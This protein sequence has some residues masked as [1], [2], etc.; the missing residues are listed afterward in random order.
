MNPT[1][2]EAGCASYPVPLP[3]EQTKT[4]KAPSRA[5]TAHDRRRTF[6]V[7]KQD[8]QLR[9]KSP[10]RAPSEG[11]QRW[12][13]S[14]SS[15]TFRLLPSGLRMSAAARSVIGLDGRKENMAGGEK[16]GK[17]LHLA[18]PSPADVSTCM[19]P[20]PARPSCPSPPLAAAAWATAPT[21]SRPSPLPRRSWKAAA[22]PPPSLPTPSRHG[23]K[24]SDARRAQKKTRAKS[25]TTA[26]CSG[27]EASRTLR[28]FFLPPRGATP[29][30]AG[31]ASKTGAREGA[32]GA[33]QT[34]W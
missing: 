20:S 5:K 33:R 23:P 17:S 28:E 22:S 25:A 26:K 16:Q 7:K 4:A 9:R 11:D 15:W 18:T 19:A 6:A 32:R 10:K 12:T 1:V 2:P 31:R 21:T 8:S 34:K 3:A 24:A 13:K 14:I 30:G 27:K 29:Q